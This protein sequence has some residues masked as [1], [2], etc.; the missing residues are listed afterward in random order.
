MNPQIPPYFLGIVYAARFY[1]QVYIALKL[2]VI[3][4]KI[5]QARAWKTLKYLGSK[6][7]KARNASF[8]KRRIGAK[9]IYVWQK[10]AHTVGDVYRHI[11]VFDAHVYV[12]AKNEV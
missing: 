5:G 8:P 10:I 7:F 6:R 3:V 1:E 4:K 2:I 11:F 12:Q 9:C